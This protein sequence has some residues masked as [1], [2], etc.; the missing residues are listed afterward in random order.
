MKEIS[1]ASPPRI[2]SHITKEHRDALKRKCIECKITFKTESLLLAHMKSHRFK[3]KPYEEMPSICSK[4]GKQFVTFDRIKMHEL[5][6]QESQSEQLDAVTTSHRSYDNIFSGEQSKNL[7]SS[8]AVTQLN[9]LKGIEKIHRRRTKDKTPQKYLDNNK[10]NYFCP[11]CGES[12]S[13]IPSLSAHAEALN[14]ASVEESCWIC[15]LCNAAF[16]RED[17]LTRHM[18]VH[19]NFMVDTQLPAHFQGEEIAISD[20]A[21]NKRPNRI[22]QV[23]TFPPKYRVRLESKAHRESFSGSSKVP[24][25]GFKILDPGLGPGDLQAQRLR[26]IS[27]WSPPVIPETQIG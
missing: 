11:D 21:Q 20:I 18:K 8:L 13:D 27:E 16:L 19:E 9:E 6:C 24:L 10:Q 17:E 4:Y 2:K 1:F 5:N 25:T 3:V 26:L 12:F 23:S 15:G 7:M 14:H 22:V